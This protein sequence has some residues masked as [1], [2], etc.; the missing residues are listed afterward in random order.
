MRWRS[1]KDELPAIGE[2]VI[3]YCESQGVQNCYLDIKR[4]WCFNYDSQKAYLN[5]TH[6]MSLPEPPKQ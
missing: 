5:I 1:V 4:Q 3:V 2:R 6:W